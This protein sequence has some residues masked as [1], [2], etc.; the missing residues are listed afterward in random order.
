VYSEAARKETDPRGKAHYW[1]G[2]GPPLWEREEETDM[3]AVHEGHVSVTPLH[4]DLTDQRR[5][6]KMA[7]WRE[8]LE[9][10]AKPARG[11]RR[12]IGPQGA[13]RP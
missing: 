13:G 8:I 2:A 1:I 7:G 12:S 5:L 11:R 10:R 6:R 3:T 4:M 9:E